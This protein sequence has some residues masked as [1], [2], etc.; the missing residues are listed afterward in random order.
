MNKLG[1]AAIAS[2]IGVALLLGGAGTLATWNSSAPIDGGTIV[3][4]NLL[5]ADGGAGVW[6]ANG[7]ATPIDLA[8]YTVVPGD[9]LTYTKAM[10]ITATGNN[11][12]ATLGLGAGSISGTTASA[13]D[14]ALAGYLTKT[15]TIDATGPG[16][17][18]T[19]GV[20]TVTAG[21]AGV[22][23][24]VTVTVTVTFP[25]SVT[26][27]DATEDAT[28]TGSVNLSGLAVTLTQS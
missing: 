2:G 23:Q 17:A 22:N 15:A 28:K 5:V 25:K 12:V 21:T 7:D 18:T 4:G 1:K 6:T 8:S 3:A 27:G 20:T 16:I 11:L 24:T 26:V 10:D 9:V 19:G 13:A 14:Q